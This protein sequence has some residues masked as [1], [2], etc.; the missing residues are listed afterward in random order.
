M[1]L[2]ATFQRVIG[3]EYAGKLAV[4]GAE[5]LAMRARAEFGAVECSYALLQQRDAELRYSD[6]GASISRLLRRVR[7]A[8]QSL[9]K[10]ESLY[11]LVFNGTVLTYR[12]CS[13]CLRPERAP[14]AIEPLAYACLVMEGMIPLLQPRFLKWRVQVAVA[15][16][17]CY[18]ATGQR[19]P[20]QAA[21]AH[22]LEQLAAQRALDRHNPVP[23]K[24]KLVARYEAA[25]AALRPR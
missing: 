11:W 21:A 7:Q 13:S 1:D 8:M 22:A 25:Y 20:A 18:E 12:L 15:L 4:E 2:T 5:A 3:D 14:L 23:P 6:S 9:V 10:Q 19:E 24:K 17:H 16:C